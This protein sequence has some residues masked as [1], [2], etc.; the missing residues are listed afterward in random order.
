MTPTIAIGLY[1]A[2]MSGACCYVVFLVVRYRRRAALLRRSSMEMAGLMQRALADGTALPVPPLVP[3][4]PDTFL[5]RMLGQRRQSEAS[6]RLALARARAAQ[7]ATA[8]T[9][10]ASGSA[11][12]QTAGHDVSPSTGA[13]SVRWL[14]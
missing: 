13:E 2:A 3:Q 12:S 5:G 9:D 11:A 6:A 7:V 1:L 10:P 4:R 14:D 8:H